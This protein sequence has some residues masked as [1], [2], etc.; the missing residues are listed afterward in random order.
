MYEPEAHQEKHTQALVK[1]FRGTKNADKKSKLI[2]QYLEKN[3]GLVL[4]RFVKE[5]TLLHMA[6]IK[7]LPVLVQYLLKQYPELV[8][9]NDSKNKSALNRAVSLNMP[10][11]VELFRQAIFPSLVHHQVDETDIED[12]SKEFAV[13]Q[14]FKSASNDKQ[15]LSDDEQSI[16]NFDK[17]TSLIKNVNDEL[18]DLGQQLESQL[19]YAGFESFDVSNVPVQEDPIWE[20]CAANQIKANLNIERIRHF[21]KKLTSDTLQGI[22]SQ[23]SPA[24][25][26]K[27][28]NKF[29]GNFDN[30]QKLTAIFV[31]KELLFWDISHSLVAKELNIKS[32]L[33][34]IFLKIKIDFPHHGVNMVFLLKSMISTKEKLVSNELYKRYLI[35]CDG[36]QN[37]IHVKEKKSFETLLL[38]TLSMKDK[39]QKE[40]IEI[41]ANEFRS[42]MLCFYHAVTI[43]EYYSPEWSDERSPHIKKQIDF[44]NNLSDYIKTF[45]LQAVTPKDCTQRIALFIRVATQLCHTSNG[46]GADLGSVNIITTSISSGALAR[47]KLS[48][49]SLSDK[50]KAKFEKLKKLNMPDFGFTML[51]KVANASSLPLVN[52]SLI[53]SDVRLSYENENAKQRYEALGTILQKILIFKRAYSV[54]PFRF[55]TNL[56]HL[57]DQRSYISNWNHFYCL[58]GRF[59]AV[60]LDAISFED[61]IEMIDYMINN[62]FCPTVRYAQEEYLPET[63][64][65][66]ILN[67]MKESLY[68]DEH[69]GEDDYKLHLLKARK[70]AFDLIT[71][72]NHSYGINLSLELI[73]QHLPEPSPIVLRKKERNSIEYENPPVYI[74]RRSPPLSKRH[75]IDA[76]PSPARRRK[77]LS[78]S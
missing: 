60:N 37:S 12:L 54:L 64:I 14:L 66:P 28:I 29:W 47:L 27:N 70:A 62:N 39:N 65:E 78:E 38:E 25:I 11:I 74:V 59:V 20:L 2:I 56:L 21:D 7:R 23:R 8:T 58:S 67:K 26:I 13:L 73:N 45:I 16:K 33:R 75:T 24:V 51:R 61:L 34:P 6:V 41:I 76:E 5:R 43:D 72:L 10:E 68:G 1:L 15:F 35:L 19:L 48:F 9:L 77:R 69:I 18:E 42:I 55:E 31:L 3:P 36:G 63:I 52:S 71:L 44:F 46:V 40:N 50:D 53:Q 30:N 57:L 49:M 32:L 4:L 22:M 17:A